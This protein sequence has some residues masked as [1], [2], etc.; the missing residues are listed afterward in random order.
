M[1]R[2]YQARWASRERVDAL[3]RSGQLRQGILLDSFNGFL[4][5]EPAGSNLGDGPILSPREA[6]FELSPAWC[7]GPPV[8]L[9]EARRLLRLETDP[10][11]G[12]LVKVS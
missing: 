7:P 8:K 3:K 6:D 5:V 4:L 12:N 1:K 11:S 10:H 2:A 9:V